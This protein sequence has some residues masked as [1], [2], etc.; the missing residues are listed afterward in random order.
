LFAWYEQILH[1]LPLGE[2]IVP[3]VLDENSS[4]WLNGDVPPV[5]RGKIAGPQ[6]PGEQQKI[7]ALSGD[8]SL[9]ANLVEKW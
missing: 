6:S 9:P 1:V 4:T 5:M 7:A 2:N 3:C 8:P